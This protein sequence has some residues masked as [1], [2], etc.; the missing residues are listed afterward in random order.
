[1]A[2]LF[3]ERMPSV[4]VLFE[5]QMPSVAVPCSRGVR[6]PEQLTGDSGLSLRGIELFPPLE[7][8][9]GGDSL[10][11]CF[12]TSAISNPTHVGGAVT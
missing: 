8:G 2:A 3:E 4:A 5:E 11:G 10:S 7:K 12:P 6:F 9:G 1:M